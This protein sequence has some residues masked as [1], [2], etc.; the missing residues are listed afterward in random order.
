V[1]STDT[2]PPS[3]QIT[4]IGYDGE[5]LTVTVSATDAGGVTRVELYIETLKAT[6]SSAPYASRFNA[7][8]LSWGIHTVQAKAYDNAGNS[9]I[10]APTTFTK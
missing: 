4:S 3:V 1:A 7:R 2:T 10:S 9:S 6:D 5:F 8:P